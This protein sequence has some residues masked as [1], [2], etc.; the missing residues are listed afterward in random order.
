M[1]GYIRRRGKD[2]WQVTVELGRRD[3]TTGRRLRRFLRARGTKRDA[4]R[5]LAEALHQRDTGV[6]VSPGKLT[7]GPT[8]SA[9]GCAT[10]RPRTSPRPRWSG[11]RPS[12]ST[13]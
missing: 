8:T 12:S 11:T 7:V 4:E 9:A 6:D 5:A 2:S 3:P 13:I 1:A 10:T